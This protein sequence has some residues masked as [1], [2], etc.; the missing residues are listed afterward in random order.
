MFIYAD[1]EHMFQNCIFNLKQFNIIFIFFLTLDN[2]LSI[3]YKLVTCPSPK[4]REI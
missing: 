1:Y 3:V 2:R 4:F